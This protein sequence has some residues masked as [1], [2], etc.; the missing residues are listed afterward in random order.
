[1]KITKNSSEK[2]DYLKT[3]KKI[4]KMNGSPRQLSKETII[5]PKNQNDSIFNESIPIKVRLIKAAHLNP[6]INISQIKKMNKTKTEEKDDKNKLNEQEEQPK[7]ISVKKNNFKKIKM[8]SSSIKKKED[9]SDIINN[10]NKDNINVKI[11]N[12]K[13]IVIMK[14]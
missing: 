7:I 1:M 5:F 11:F 6:N 9:N 12:R 14:F 4:N 2:F 8:T 13:K 10:F 3:I